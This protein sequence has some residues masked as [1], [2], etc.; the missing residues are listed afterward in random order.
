MSDRPQEPPLDIE[1]QEMTRHVDERVTGLLRLR[2]AREKDIARREKQSPRQR[3]ANGA[4]G[5][6]PDALDVSRSGEPTHCVPKG[7]VYGLGDQLFPG[8]GHSALRNGV[9]SSVDSSGACGEDS[10]NPPTRPAA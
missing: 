3:E 10:T 7:P 2:L 4:K 6:G 5:A 1:L 9:S 8:R